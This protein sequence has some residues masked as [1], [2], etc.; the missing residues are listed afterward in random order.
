MSNGYPAVPGSFG[1]GRL[2]QASFAVLCSDVIGS[3]GA[4]PGGIGGGGKAPG[5]AV[6]GGNGYGGIGGMLR[7][8]LSVK[9]E[10]LAMGNKESNEK[11]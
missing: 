4:G 2:I 11:T 3:A 7:S 10:G 6:T 1:S 5:G 8:K 9:I